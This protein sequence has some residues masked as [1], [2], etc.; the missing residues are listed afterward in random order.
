VQRNWH[1]ARGKLAGR[2]R[3]S[4]AAAFLAVLFE[5]LC[6]TAPSSP[7]AAELSLIVIGVSNVQSGPSSILGQTLLLGSTSYFNLVNQHGSIHGRF[8]GIVNFKGGK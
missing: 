5:N 6:C 2:S 1:W 8:R 4:A 7:A 3:H